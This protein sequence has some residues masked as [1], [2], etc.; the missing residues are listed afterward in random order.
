[1]TALS[2]PAAP[3]DRW[4]TA[5]RGRLNSSGRIVYGARSPKPR[6]PTDEVA[7]E[8]GSAAWPAWARAGVAGAWELVDHRADA[9]RFVLGAD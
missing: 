6:K 1:M 7:V 5:A 9:A 2:I 4:L 8:F 3:L